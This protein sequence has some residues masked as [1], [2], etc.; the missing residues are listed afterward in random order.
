MNGEELALDVK[1]KIE[2]LHN[3]NLHK[4]NIPTY[5]KDEQ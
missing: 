3:S 1:E 5:R 4:F 2:K